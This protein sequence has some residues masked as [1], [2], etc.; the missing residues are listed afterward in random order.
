MDT[1]NGAY[2]RRRRVESAFILY[3]RSMGEVRNFNFEPLSF[4]F[5]LTS[6]TIGRLSYSLSSPPPPL[7]VLSSR[8]RDLK[9]AL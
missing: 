6:S 9:H 4:I 5:P 2:T 3:G 7:R 8:G 1:D